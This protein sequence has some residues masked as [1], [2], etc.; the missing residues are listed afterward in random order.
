ME[1]ND[2]QVGY[3]PEQRQTKALRFVH[4]ALEAASKDA[5]P[6]PELWH[7]T[8]GS[9]LLKMLPKMALWTTHYECMNDAMEVRHGYFCLVNYLPRY[10]QERRNGKLKPFDYYNGLFKALKRRVLAEYAPET[11]KLPFNFSE[12]YSQDLYQ[13]FM[14]CFSEE[15]DDL[16]QW[17]AYG[18]GEGGVALCFDPSILRNPSREAG[19]SPPWLLKVAYC[20]ADKEKILS[21]FLD[22]ALADFEDRRE[23]QNI[24]DEQAS[25]IGD[26]VAQSWVPAFSY[27]AAL[28]KDNS[29]RAEKEWRL[30]L[31]CEYAGHN[32]ASKL[33]F[34]P[35]RTAVARHYPLSFH[36]IPVTKIMVGP[37]RQQNASYWSIKALLQKNE[38]SMEVCNSNSSYQSV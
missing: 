28:F 35:R 19:I 27:M 12:A 2:D 37:S 4:Q 7:Y 8:S 9:T 29:F 22:G 34:T 21:K 26:Q 31:R 36:K 30:L 20:E 3:I 18:G 1:Q 33:E 10:E 23:S 24:S 14:A 25:S 15:R 17:R 38:K 16:A 6:P 13:C 5:E 11:K 32:F